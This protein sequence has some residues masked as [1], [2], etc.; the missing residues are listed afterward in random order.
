MTSRLNTII[1][2]SSNKNFSAMSVLTWDSGHH[3][4]HLNTHRFY[5]NLNNSVD[6]SFLIM[7]LF[8]QVMTGYDLT[9]HVFLLCLAWKFPREDNKTTPP[10]LQ[11]HPTNQSLGQRVLTLPFGIRSELSV[12]QWNREDKCL[13]RSYYVLWFNCLSFI[14]LCSIFHCD[15]KSDF[16]R[17]L[18]AWSNP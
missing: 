16:C 7:Y 4:H 8:F 12:T 15:K 2:K 1:F 18:A 10:L 17:H 14:V 6:F 3:H 13:K 5:V 11:L 9:T